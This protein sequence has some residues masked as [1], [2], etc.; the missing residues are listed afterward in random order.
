MKVEAVLPSEAS[1]VVFGMPGQCRSWRAPTPSFPLMLARWYLTASTLVPRSR[2]ISA[3]PMPCR[4]RSST[5]H[6]AG[7]RRSGWGGLPRPRIG[8]I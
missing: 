6:S 4:T 1:C 8:L 7:V 2:A 5:R 3:R